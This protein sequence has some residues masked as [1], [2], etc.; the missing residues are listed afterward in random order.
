MVENKYIKGKNKGKKCARG[1][2]SGVSWRGKTSFSEEDGKR[3]IWFG[4]I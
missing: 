1:V 4:P 2:N 3:E